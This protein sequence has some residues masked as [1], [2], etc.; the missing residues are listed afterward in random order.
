M[1]IVY[2]AEKKELQALIKESFREEI[3]TFLKGLN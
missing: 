1:K 2:I 3:D